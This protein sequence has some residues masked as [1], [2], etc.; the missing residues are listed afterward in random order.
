MSE[1]VAILQQRLERTMADHVVDDVLGDLLLLLL[2]EQQPSLVG[3]LDD[4][5]CDARL[6]VGNAHADRQRG[7]DAAQDLF[8]NQH[9]RRGRG[10][11]RV[12]QRP[13]CPTIAGWIG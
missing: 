7:I 5:L 1:T 11:A 13:R 8:M 12:A 2:V 10:V 4:E 9:G 6:Q 3:E